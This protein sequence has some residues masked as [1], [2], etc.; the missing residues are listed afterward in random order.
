MTRLFPYQQQ[1]I[2]WLITKQ[3]ALLADEM[4]LGKSAQAII[5]A[6]KLLLQRILVV[7]PAVARLNWEREF[8]KFSTFSRKFI[9]VKTGKDII[10]SDHSVIISPDLC[11]RVATTSLGKFDLVILDEAHY[12]KN[13]NAKRTRAIFGKGGLIHEQT[14]QTS[15]ATPTQSSDQTSARIWC[16]SGTPAP[17]HAGELWP[18][19][20]TFGRTCLSHEDFNGFVYSLKEFLE[21]RL[22]IKLKERNEKPSQNSVDSLLR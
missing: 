17:N 10:P 4:G 16:L 1:G 5:S 6:D 9:I 8:G 15:S 22:T 19:L 14:R 21:K 11:T 3:L 20:R 13:L 18:I 7:C 2:N 12:F